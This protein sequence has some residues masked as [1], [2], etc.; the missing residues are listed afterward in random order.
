MQTG[1]ETGRVTDR[2]NVNYLPCKLEIMLSAVRGLYDAVTTV[3]ASNKDHSQA[4]HVARGVT[5]AF[6]LNLRGWDE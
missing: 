3:E 4:V 5:G 1:R 2:H 6:V